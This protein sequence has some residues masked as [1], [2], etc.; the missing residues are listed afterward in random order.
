MSVNQGFVCS[1]RSRKYPIAAPT[2]TGPT[3]VKGNSNASARAELE[4][5]SLPLFLAGIGDECSSGL[6]FEGILSEPGERLRIQPGGE[7]DK[8]GDAE[9]DGLRVAHDRTRCFAGRFEPGVDDDAE[10]VVE[11]RN[12]VENGED[13]E[14]R[15]MRFDEGKENEI[16]AHET[17]GG[18]NP[19]ER[20]HKDEQEDGGGG[21]AL[22]QAV[23]VFEFFADET[24]LAQHDDHR[25]S[26][27]GHEYIGEQ[28]EGD[29]GG[30]RVV[31]LSALR[32]KSPDDAEQNVPDVGNGGV[33][34]KALDVR[35]GKRGEIAPGEGGD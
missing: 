10:V 33:G 24:F 13:R 19:G 14:H 5:L 8:Y 35:L 30:A 26:S 25:E 11:R 12:D 6:L 28:I 2:A 32:R 15:V 20:K 18:R 27:G 4:L 21:A 1:Q 9:G 22:V 17:G 29:P 34:E 23:Q 3:R 7:G 16:F 31:E